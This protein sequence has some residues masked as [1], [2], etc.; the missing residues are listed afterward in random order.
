MAIVH[1][2]IIINEEQFIERAARFQEECQAKVNKYYSHLSL[3]AIEAGARGGGSA[4]LGRVYFLLD[5]CIKYLYNKHEEKQERKRAEEREMLRHTIL[6]QCGWHKCPGYTSS[7][8]VY[9]Q[10]IKAVS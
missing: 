9:G 4:V 7:A 2:E 6:C 3:L 8:R 5:S 10:K 1:V